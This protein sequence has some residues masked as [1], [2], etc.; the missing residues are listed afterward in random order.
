MAAKSPTKLN[1]AKELER[2]RANAKKALNTLTAADYNAAELMNRDLL[3]DKQGSAMTTY[4][5]RALGP[6]RELIEYLE[7]FEER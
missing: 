6:L 4:F 2:I 1:K 5:L 7:N 3:D